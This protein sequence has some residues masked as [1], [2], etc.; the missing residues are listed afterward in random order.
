VSDLAVTSPHHR[1]NNREPHSYQPESPSPLP[2]MDDL[3]AD[4]TPRYISLARLLRGQIEDGTYGR[5]ELLPSSARLAEVHQ[6]SRATALRALE[7]LKS[8][9]YVRHIES[10]PHQVIWEHTGQPEMPS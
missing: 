3:D 4:Y 1:G 7:A 6:V 8:T 5:G 9:G 2:Q 10:M